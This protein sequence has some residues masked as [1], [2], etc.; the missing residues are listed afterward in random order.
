MRHQ[1]LALFYFVPLSCTK[2]T[3][4]SAPEV[5]ATSE[6]DSLAECRIPSID[7]FVEW[8]ASGEG[9]TQPAT[10]SLLKKV[11]SHYQAEI[12]FLDSE[13]WHVFALWLGQQFEAS[14][15]LS[16]SQGLR[17]R[18]SAT[19]NFYVQL[20]PGFAWSGGQQWL[21]LLP[22]TDGELKEFEIPFNEDHWT[23]LPALGVPQYPFTQALKDAR[24]LVFVGNQQNKITITSLQ[25]DSYLP[26]C[27]H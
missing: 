27:P 25:I 14:V 15:D 6:V 16:Q 2:P 21:T 19:E 4:L 20:R 7:R 5:S 23:N 17:I 22:K 13:H 12:E 10:G 18:Y 8:R 9:R 11:N 1:L 3:P 24:G 26:T